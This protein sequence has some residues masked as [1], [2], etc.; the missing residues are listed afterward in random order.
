MK[1]QKN[2]WKLLALVLALALL[3]GCVQSVPEATATPLPTAAQSELPQATAEAQASWPVTVT[4]MLGGEVTVEQEPQRIVSLA[5]SNT[6]ILYALGVGDRLVGVDAYSDYPEEAKGIAQVGD[7]SGPN[8][9]A[10]LA[11]E[12]DVIFA[13]RKLQAEVIEQLQSLG[14]VVVSLESTAY[15]D[16]YRS[17]ELAAAVTG[18]DASSLMESMRAQQAEA[19]SLA[20]AEKPSVYFCLGFG[21]YGDYTCGKGSFVTEV[22]ELAGYEVVTAGVEVPWPSYSLEQLAADDPDYILV[23]GDQATADAFCAAEGYRELRAVKEG[24]VF[25]VDANVSSRPGP[26]ITQFMLDAAKLH[27]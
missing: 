14:A 15:E 19:E 27:Q 6:E 25:P 9:E 24:R 18:C 8:V 2:I 13:S 5:A 11:L 17:I 20:A 4:D 7:Y 26:R 21:E 12:P 1:L 10:I 22:L 3:A 23:S 16:I